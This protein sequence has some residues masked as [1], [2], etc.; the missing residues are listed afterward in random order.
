MLKEESRAGMELYADFILLKDIKKLSTT[1]KS[2]WS[3]E[4]KKYT[5]MVSPILT[6]DLIKIAIEKY[7][8]VRVEKVNT[9]NCPTK[10]KIVGRKIGFKTKLKKAI[11]TLNPSDEISLFSDI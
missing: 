4:D 2:L 10:R 8:N 11:I 7:F 6:K 9:L 1:K 3:L 5:F